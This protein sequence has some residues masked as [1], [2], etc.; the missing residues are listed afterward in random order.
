MSVPDMYHWRQTC[1][2]GARHEF[3]I[4]CVSAAIDDSLQALVTDIPRWCQS[5]RTVDL[6]LVAGIT[7]RSQ[8]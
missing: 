8:M 5:C 7:H 6:A 2:T 1:R 4:A 3:K